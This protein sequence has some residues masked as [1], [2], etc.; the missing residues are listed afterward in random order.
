MVILNQ[1]IL[2]LFGF[3]LSVIIDKVKMLEVQKLYP[4]YRALK[5]RRVENVE[6]PFERRSGME[7]RSP[8]RVALDQNLT[9][10]IFEIKSRVSQLQ[11]SNPKN[12]EKI[13]FTH[14]SAKVLQNNI[15]A[16]QFIR[17]TKPKQPDPIKKTESQSPA[18]L[19]AGILASVLGGIVAATLIGPI[20]VGIAIGI[21]AYFGLKL[22]KQVVS[23]HLENK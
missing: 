15:N 20:G 9:R 16:D 4:Q 6:V 18:A 12:I 19:A 14:N 10:D 7:R 22:L 2:F 5:D 23:L 1:A 17:T 21:G 3:K 13:A 11:K 8:D